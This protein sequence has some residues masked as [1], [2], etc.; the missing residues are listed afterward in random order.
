MLP[1]D[2]YHSVARAVVVFLGDAILDLLKE[3]SIPAYNM[4]ALQQLAKDVAKLKAFAEGC[5][6]PN[7][8]VSHTC[9]EMVPSVEA[10][11]QNER[12]PCA[13]AAR[14]QAAFRR[15]VQLPHTRTSC[16]YQACYCCH[17]WDS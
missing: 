5:N 14:F 17:S 10:Q 9:R 2:V 8:V 13:F 7:I 3:D 16:V 1:S 4:Y 11:Q 12:M 15:H 6:V